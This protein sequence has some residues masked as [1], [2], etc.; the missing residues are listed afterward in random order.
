MTLSICI[1][2]T[3]LHAKTA[4]GRGIYEIFTDRPITTSAAVQQV[5]VFL[6][7]N[8]QSIA[9]V[10]NS[11]RFKMA[12]SIYGYVFKRTCRVYPSVLLSEI[13]YVMQ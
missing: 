1:L 12:S 6:R 13:N 10:R 7:F 4:T 8:F 9:K 5:A 3:K 11:S 2:T